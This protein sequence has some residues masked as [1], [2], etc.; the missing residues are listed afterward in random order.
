MAPFPFWVLFNV[1]AVYYLFQ[2][3]YLLHS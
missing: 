3:F 1:F 2:L